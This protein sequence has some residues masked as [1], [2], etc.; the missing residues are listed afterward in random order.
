MGQVY[1]LHKGLTK[2]GKPRYFFS[3]KAGDGP[4]DSV[5]EGYEIYEK[6]NGQVFLR[7]RMPTSITPEEVA[8]VKK[9]LKL[10]GVSAFL[11]EVE[12]N[13]IVV[14]TAAQTPTSLERMF[15]EFG[16]EPGLRRKQLTE[17]FQQQGSFTP[18]LRF[19]LAD[20]TKRTFQ[21]ERWC[22]KG[23]ID[24]WISLLHGRGLLPE[25][26]AKYGPHLDK[27]SFYELF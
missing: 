16:I 9:G 21:T 6:P 2:S 22:F 24:G 15:E 7:K 14:H 11:V 8:L 19:I 5:P 17:Q 3:M 4:A 1:H 26:V 20:E 10:A 25:M 12:K 18:V 13:A 27:E 23:S